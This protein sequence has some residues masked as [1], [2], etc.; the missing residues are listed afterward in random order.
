MVSYLDASGKKHFALAEGKVI[1]ACVAL[2]VEARIRV[3]CISWLQISPCETRFLF[4]I[5]LIVGVG[6]G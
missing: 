6:R 4:G 5:A 3:H 1:L 2:E